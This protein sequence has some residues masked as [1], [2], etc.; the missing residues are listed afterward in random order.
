VNPFTKPKTGWVPGQAI[1]GNLMKKW[2]GKD[3]AFDNRLRYD[4]MIILEW[5]AFCYL[6]SV[7]FSEDF[8]KPIQDILNTGNLISDFTKT[9]NVSPNTKRTTLW[10]DI[11]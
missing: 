9:P 6:N 1:S 5:I 10:D 7:P 8:G 4:G 11:I 2:F 3:E